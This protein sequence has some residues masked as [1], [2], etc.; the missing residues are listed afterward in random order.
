MNCSDIYT[1]F[2]GQIPGRTIE[3]NLTSEASDGFAMSW[4]S[5]FR[6]KPH[7]RSESFVFNSGIDIRRQ[8]SLV[9]SIPSAFYSASSG[10]GNLLS[11][12]SQKL[13]FTK[14]QSKVVR[15]SRSFTSKEPHVARE[16][17]VADPWAS[18]SFHRLFNSVKNLLHNEPNANDQIINMIDKIIMNINSS[19]S[20]QA[21]SNDQDVFIEMIESKSKL[22]QCENEQPCLR[23]KNEI[24]GKIIESKTN[25]INDLQKFTSEQR[26]KH[27]TI[28]ESLKNEMNHHLKIAVNKLEY[29]YLRLVFFTASGAGNNYAFDPDKDPDIEYG[30]STACDECLSS[31]TS[32]AKRV[33]VLRCPGGVPFEQNLTSEAS[34]GFAMSWRSAFRAKPHERSE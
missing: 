17:Q 20:N 8:S 3:Q 11:Q 14:F 4:R 23:D 15:Q 22:F 13:Q 30:T 27:E 6:A 29:Y 1:I 33:T 10:V 31:K 18:S 21:I 5:A 7:E 25:Y 26:E 12:K 34:D 16:P 32:R 24:L 9:Q 2:G 28:V 19:S